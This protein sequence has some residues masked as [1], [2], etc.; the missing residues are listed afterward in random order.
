[1]NKIKA[2]KYQTVLNILSLL[3]LIGTIL[4]LII[5]WNTI[6][7]KIPGHYNGN[8]IIDRWG[9]KSELIIPLVIGIIMYLGLSF[10]ER[11]TKIWNI[12]VEVNEINREKVYSLTRELLITSKFFLTLNFS[13]LTI[14]SSLSLNLPN[15]YTL[16]F[17]GLLFVVIVVYT[18]RLILLNRKVKHI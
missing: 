11:C 3:V 7:Q 16:I 17:V 9:N 15:W 1:M 10:V 5:F 12:G 2:T 8:G 13:F 14:N 6:P 18:I 4:Y